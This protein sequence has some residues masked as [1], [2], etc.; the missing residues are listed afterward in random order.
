MRSFVFCLL[1]L[2]IC[3]LLAPVSVLHAEEDATSYSL[4]FKFTPGEFV[5]YTVDAQNQFTV[6]LNQDKETTINS[7][8]TQK[9]YRVVAVDESGNA[10]LET[11]IDR[12]QM[13]VQFNNG[14]PATFD[15]IQP[16][17][18]D[19]EQFIPIRRTIGRPSRIVYSPTGEVIA[20]LELQTTSEG[21]TFKETTKKGPKKLENDKTRSLGFL[22]PLP[23]DSIK[24]G[25]S[26]NEDFEAEVSV[27]DVLRKK[28]PIR[29]IFTLKSV[30]DDVAVITFK[31]KIMERLN[32][33]QFSIQLIQKTP[34]GTIKLNLEKGV[35]TSQDVSLD[36]A[37]VGVFNGQGAMRAVTHV[38][39]TLVDPA[40]LAQ[41]TAE[42]DS[43]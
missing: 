21:S 33:P 11:M 38:V 25:D 16:V 30:E 27:G 24:V 31:T 36:K 20:V 1:S 34:S 19:L 12:V 22:I 40:S 32:D 15:S 9:H 7:T 8:Q 37:E 6:Q 43:E 4:R 23:E 28:V 2:S 26:W 18:K 10:T 29:R 35:I 41:K 3:Q 5:H 42:T 39:E 13:S 17:E 14:T